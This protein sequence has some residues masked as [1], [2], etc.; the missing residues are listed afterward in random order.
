[1]RIAQVLLRY[2]APGGVETHVRE[3][4]KR[5]AAMGDPVKI[6]ASDL[7]DEEGWVR[8]SSPSREV[9]GIPVERFPVLKR[10]IPF[11][12]MPMMPGLIRALATEDPNVIHAHSHRY[13]HVLQSAL[14]ADA[15]EIPLVVSTHYHPADP[16]T[17]GWKRGMLRVQ[18]HL[19]GTTAYR[20]A[21]AVVVE[22]RREAS[23]VGDFVPQRKIRIIPPGIDLDSWSHL[24]DP[25]TAR[26]R[27]GL[28]PRYLLFAGRLAPN[29]GLPF[30]LAAWAG[31]PSELRIPLVL[32]GPDWGMW[33]ELSAE[34]DRRGVRTG[35]IRRDM[36][37]DP[38]V[39]RAVFAGASAFVLPSEYEAFGLVLLEAMAS[40]LPIVATRV[41]GVPE[42]IRDGEWGRL[43]P[44]GDGA[45][46]GN[47]L[48]E[49][50]TSPEL[51][52]RWGREGVA[53]VR[54]NY[55][56]ERT[57]RALR[58]LYAEVTGTG[59]RSEVSGS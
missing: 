46:L 26:S 57:A 3:V 9:D 37:R 19:F 50:L 30:L 49:I 22:T 52:R 29:K 21:R 2:D 13:G 1:M 17:T 10:L 12:T 35:L 39:Y 24:P 42:V 28:P 27:T 48:R 51:A 11:L 25:D 43:V 36:E 7:Y 47:A 6:F 34:A 15:R 44:Y 53:H 32:M 55:S 54:A 41:G 33:E 45:A 5:L 56:W 38:E 4:A 20:I 23:A 16:R 31:L 8:S 59:P 14:V 18:D 58:D 40:A